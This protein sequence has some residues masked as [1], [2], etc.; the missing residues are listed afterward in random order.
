MKV[1]CTHPKCSKPENEI[2]DKEINA[3]NETK[4]C[5][6]DCQMPL[7]LQGHFVAINLLG[8]GGFGRTFLAKDLDFLEPNF[9]IKQLRL[10]HTSGQ[11]F[12]PQELERRQNLFVREA[13]T[14]FTLRHP[15][16]PRLFAFFSLELTDKNGLPQ[17]FFYLVQ[18]YIEGC[19][20]AEELS[21]KPDKKFSE[22]E[23]IN[24]LKEIL[25]IL[26]YIHHD[27]GTHN[28]HYIH[29]DIKPENI[30]RCSR[31]GKLHLID[32][33]A[34]KQVVQGFEP[35][36][37]SI[38]LD[39]RFAPPEQW[40][41]KAVSPA[42]DLYATATTCLCLLTGIRNVRGL[43]FN[44]CWRDHVKVRDHRFALVLD[45]MLKS[46]QQIRPQSATEVLNALSSTTN[47]DPAATTENEPNGHLSPPINPDRAKSTII[48]PQSWFRRFID[49][50]S[51]LPRSWRSIIRFVIPFVLGIVIAVTFYYLKNVLPPDPTPPLAED[52][53]RGEQAL[54]SP[55]NL[56][57]PEC[58]K[59][60]AYKEKGMRAF[61]E[62]NFKI[63]TELFKQARK[64]FSSN[65]TKC[66][67]DPETLIYEHNSQ[68]AQTPANLSLP[69]IAVVIPIDY[70]DIALEILRGVAQALDEQRPQFQILIAKENIDNNTS[71]SQGVATYIS[72]GNIP[73]DISSFEKSKIL[74]VIGHYTSEN[75]Q[76]AGKTYG[77][78]ALGDEKLVLISPTSTGE[79]EL[80]SGNDISSKNLKNLY[81]FR[82]A[83]S[84]KTA[85]G[86]LAK[87]MSQTLHQKD[88]VILYD[89]GSP[90]YSKS[91]A[92]WFKH[93]MND[94][95]DFKLGD[96]I[97]NCNLIIDIEANDC[98]KSAIKRQAKVLILFPSRATFKEVKNI[99]KSNSR[100]FEKILAG[101][102][103]YSKDTLNI[104]EAEG[105]IIAVSFHVNQAKD[106]F[107]ERATEIGWLRNMTW[108]SITSYDATQVFVKALSGNN[109]RKDLT[110]REIY[111]KLNDS[112]FSAIGAVVDVSFNEYHDRKIV[113]SVGIL[114][115]VK[116]S[117]S[118]SD[119]YYFDLVPQSQYNN[120]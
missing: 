52:F 86:D 26:T 20:L 79:R 75:T 105:M 119:E 104:R 4:I 60:Y 73:G 56:S 39:P 47:P 87:Y 109:N 108:R 113:N 118:N 85:A 3:R 45:S 57:T 107:K 92:T 49:W 89:P 80:Y 19:N 16:I 48:L 38:V 91:L 102:V 58:N 31:D 14:L 112:R 95:L 97:N 99:I 63:S 59:A 37:T 71:G 1:Y 76:I 13:K 64:Q 43:L 74:G 51:T 61:K 22:D 42:S 94:K 62:G 6:N 65:Q 77:A 53:S 24:I 40:D 41:K 44:S 50:I 114:V 10:T 17:N 90:Y 27:E 81:V 54:I 110:R 103:L 101:D 7:I 25:N 33:G 32:F 46:E 2:S 68:I 120:P 93:E 67:V 98:I 34:V 106:A 55:T 96:H 78:E 69:T 83:S 29:R 111:D 66:E 100:S 12:T 9:V 117:D 82:T 115:E 5:C 23:V 36:T 70:N 28:E 18:D 84:D 11:I 88:G 35:E 21:N 8:E 30:M 116:K 15:Q 72:Q